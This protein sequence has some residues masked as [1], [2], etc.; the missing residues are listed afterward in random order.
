MNNRLTRAKFL[1]SRSQR[2]LSV[3]YSGPDLD[4]LAGLYGDRVDY[5]NSGVSVTLTVRAQAKGIFRALAGAPL[6]VG[7][8]S[9]H[10]LIGTWQRRKS[11]FRATYDASDPQTKQT[12]VRYRNGDI[13][14]SQ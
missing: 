2:H 1:P 14:T 6:E 8:N 5:T 4:A 3:A 12:R 7:W 11:F 9:Q 13:D 10:S